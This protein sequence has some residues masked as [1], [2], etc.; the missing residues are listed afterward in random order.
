MTM[1]SCE[2]DRLACNAADKLYLG[3]E[4]EMVPLYTFVNLFGS[5]YLFSLVGSVGLW[6]LIFRGGPS[7]GLWM[8]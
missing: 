7:V 2:N 3:S 1:A 5:H 8:C 4:F 6:A